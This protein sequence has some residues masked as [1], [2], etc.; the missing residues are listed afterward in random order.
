VTTATVLVDV[1]V[2]LGEPNVRGGGV[3]GGEVK[4]KVNVIDGSGGRLIGYNN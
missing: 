2:T 3:I 4:V 1:D